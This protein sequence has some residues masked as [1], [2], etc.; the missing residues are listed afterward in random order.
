M[1]EAE[2]TRL[3]LG[4]YFDHVEYVKASDVEYCEKSEVIVLFV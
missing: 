1:R 4:I 3:N 2:D